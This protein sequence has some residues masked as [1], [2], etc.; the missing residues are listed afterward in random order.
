MI[1]NLIVDYTKEGKI[2]N[3]EYSNI[4]YVNNFTKRI[5]FYNPMVN[6]PLHKFWYYIPNAKIIK[7][8]PNNISIVTSSS[9]KQL[10]ESLN[11]LDETT[12]KIIRNIK[13]DYTIEPSIILN[14]NYPPMMNLIIDSESIIYNHNNEVSDITLIKPNSKIMTYIELDCVI[15]GSKEAFK[16]WRII[17]MKEIKPMELGFNL[18][19]QQNA[20]PNPNPNININMFNQNQSI[21]YTIPNPNLNQQYQ[22]SQQSQN[23]N[24]LP[25][26]QQNQQINQTTK[27][28]PTGNMGLNG[29][30]PPTQQQLLDM[31]GKLKK[32]SNG[33][34]HSQKKTEHKSHM[35]LKKKDEEKCEIPIAPPPPIEPEQETKQEIQSQSLVS[36][37]KPELKTEFKS[38]LEMRDNEKKLLEDMRTS[39]EEWKE[40]QNKDK[41]SHDNDIKLWD[42]LIEKINKIIEENKSKDNMSESLTDIIS[43]NISQNNSHSDDEEDEEIFVIKRPTVIKQTKQNEVEEED[44]EV[45]I[46]KPTIKN[47]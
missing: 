17:Q 30:I 25:K 14:S 34:H 45:M 6:E 20:N 44:D 26:N 28:K 33:P 35:Q 11:S 37:I 47:R 27:D 29:F 5:K 23:T 1:S 24:Q 7:K 38:K 16:K 46:L 8:G 22:Q 43:Q 19:H 40:Q 36:V 39:L 9:E 10:I 42:N 21:P 41:I 31:M 15:L 2:N 3:I 13:G 4:E 12:N 32:S 18:F